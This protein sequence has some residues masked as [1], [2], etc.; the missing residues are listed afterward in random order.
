MVMGENEKRFASSFF[1]QAKEKKLCLGYVTQ[2]LN[3]FRILVLQ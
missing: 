3:T 1:Y 2:S